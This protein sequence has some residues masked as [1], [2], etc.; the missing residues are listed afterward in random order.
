MKQL[1]PSAAV[2]GLLAVQTLLMLGALDFN[3][4]TVQAQDSPFELPVQLIGFPVIIVAVKMSNFVKKLAYALSPSTYRRKAK[5]D[6][7][8][9]TS[10][11]APL[12]VLKAQEMILKEMGPDACVYEKVCSAY[13]EA[14]ALAKKDRRSGKTGV[15]RMDWEKIISGYMETGSAKKKYYMLSV[16]LGDV[17]GSP[18]FCSRIARKINRCDAK[19]NYHH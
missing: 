5:R 13:A 14:A 19:K 15:D 18:E 4:N 10:G 2:A 3:G 11:S 17:L 7:E 16:F 1:V 6:L 12:D 9:V 8:A